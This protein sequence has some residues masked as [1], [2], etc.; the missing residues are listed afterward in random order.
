MPPI[1]LPLLP[2]RKI[3]KQW[4]IH[5]VEEEWRVDPRTGR[6]SWVAV[7]PS[8]VTLLPQHVQERSISKGFGKLA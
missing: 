3:P 6:G 8:S 4:T 1:L 2:L 7:D 5:D